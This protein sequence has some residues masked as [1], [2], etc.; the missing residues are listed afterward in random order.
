MWR[1]AHS[2]CG[3][4]P[5]ERM[6]TLRDTSRV[7]LTPAGPA[8]PT[9]WAAVFI[10]LSSVLLAT[11][12]DE[13]VEAARDGNISK[14]A[15]LAAAGADVNAPN[16]R[17][18][19]A[20][21][22]AAAGDEAETVKWLL[23]HGADPNQHAKCSDFGGPATTPLCEASRTGALASARLL[24]A[25]GADVA[26]DDQL[27][28]QLANAN[29]RVEVLKLLQSSG[30]QVWPD[31]PATHLHLPVTAKPASPELTLDLADTGAPARLLSTSPPAARSSKS[32]VRLAV[33]ADEPNASA[34]DL[35]FAQLSKTPGVELVERSELRRVINEQ[36]LTLAFA[37]DQANYQKVADLL[38]ADALLL[39]S[40]RTLGGKNVVESRLLR[41]NPGLN[42]YTAFRPAPLEDMN[43]WAES[44]AGRVRDIATRS[45]APKAIALSILHLRA[46]LG[47]ATGH[48]VESSLTPL[49]TERLA[50]MPG[51]YLMERTDLDR[52]VHEQPIES[53][54]F[55]TAAWLLDGTVDLDLGGS[56]ALTANL[57][58]RP[59]NGSKPVSLAIRGRSG[60]LIAL[61]EEIARQI[62]KTLAASAPVPKPFPAAEE[63][64]RYLR[65]G[66]WALDCKL[67]Q[68]A[69][70]D[71]ET[72][73][74]LGEHSSEAARLR[75]QSATSVLERI[76]SSYRSV[77]N[78]S[79][80][81]DNLIFSRTD[82]FRHPG[83]PTGLPGPDEI[84]DLAMHLLEI[85]QAS[86][87][88]LPAGDTTARR[89]WLTLGDAALRSALS[90]ALLIDSA[91]LKEQYADR[92]Q[93]WRDAWKKVANAQLASS[94]ELESDESADTQRYWRYA[95]ALS[96]LVRE[97]GEVVPA[98]RALLQFEPKAHQV[99]VRGLIRSAVQFQ[100][101]D[102][103][104][105]VNAPGQSG[106]NIPRG[107]SRHDW[108]Q[109][110][111]EMQAS[112]EPDDVLW[113]WVCQ[114]HFDESEGTALKVMDLI[115]ERRSA[116][117]DSP[118]RFEGV[119]SS[120][121]LW[122]EK[123]SVTVPGSPQRKDLSAEVIAFRLKCYMYLCR[124]GNTL[125]NTVQVMPP[126]RE[127]LS[128]AQKSELKAALEA[129]FARET[130]LRSIGDFKLGMAYYKQMMLHGLENIDA[131]R[132][133]LAVTRMWRPPDG[134][135]IDNFT[136]QQRGLWA[137]DKAWFYCETKG[138][139]GAI[140]AVDLDTMQNTVIDLPAD[141]PPLVATRQYETFRTHFAVT[142]EQIVLARG[143]QYVALYDRRSTKWEFFP[144]LP[145]VGVPI[146]LGQD[147]YFLIATADS[148]ALAH[149]DL[150]T[151]KV[152]LPANTRRQPAESPLDDPA[153]IL[154]QVEQRGDKLAVYFS[155]RK[156]EP[157]D[158]SVDVQAWSPKTRQWE[159]QGR[160]ETYFGHV[161]APGFFPASWA[162]SGQPDTISNRATQTY[163]IH[164]IPNERLEFKFPPLGMNMERHPVC[165][166][167][168]PKGILLPF[169][170]ES[171][172]FW[173]VPDKELREYIQT[174]MQKAPRM[175]SNPGGN[176]APRN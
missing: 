111:R 9:I 117:V 161:E 164:Y 82:P 143:G 168:C 53:G 38:K 141:S 13:M 114:R 132:P 121:R 8:R 61:R 20:L 171:G 35:V 29:G 139:R 23:A 41:T 107:G 112:K 91:E 110:I 12:A 59:A 155:S 80:P 159:T 134:R 3:P 95:S 160:L 48:N 140:V 156:K 97:P 124:E 138:G 43:G 94:Q 36:K 18:A 47:N 24:L 57:E 108:I 128:A 66:R 105:S 165:W 72:A 63:A 130:T 123:L 153:L 96:L 76:Y 175:F 33:I 54:G 67:P 142:P 69:W 144:D 14:V 85:Y 136:E 98:Y 60:D 162:Y 100:G 103:L 176:P 31:H 71:A 25:A 172:G 173:F 34:A 125:L 32:K 50:Q 28:T 129:H 167:M 86:S 16:T 119:I 30:G 58:L 10:L 68:M 21:H 75:V 39:L 174:N 106:D 83:R 15:A 73:W 64:A 131:A 102:R 51:V 93:E 150:K 163:I 122:T 146:I 52:L 133:M 56:D 115:W 116:Y 89:E 90:P 5:L 49:L 92:L 70:H 27:A 55:W 118:G 46:S 157:N 2:C 88:N 170:G 26:A 120:A 158:L 81:F 135:I 62:M 145:A 77:R 84:L 104:P 11:P 149:L 19:G 152:D 113:G 45:L 1:R 74:A 17:G 127:F 137:E 79:V 6:K 148:G 42:L 37:A 169:R 65:E 7:P 147:C 126:R 22:L 166:L 40:A 101:F 154:R 78:S 87:E 109:L 4:T 151:H 99:S 44:L